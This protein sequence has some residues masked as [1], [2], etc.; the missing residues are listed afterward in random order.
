MLDDVKQQE[1]TLLECESPV[2][3]GLAPSEGL[4]K[5]F[6]PLLILGLLF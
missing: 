3:A 6:T 4:K 2:F 1:F 5:P